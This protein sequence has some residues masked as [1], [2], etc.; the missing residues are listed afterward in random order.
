MLDEAGHFAELGAHHFE[1]L[2]MEELFDLGE[3]FEEDANVRADVRVERERGAFGA[4]HEAHVGGFGGDALRAE[5]VPAAGDVEAAVGASFDEAEVAGDEAH[6]L[7][8]LVREKKR[9]FFYEVRML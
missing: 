6:F 4:A 1:D 8:M 7:S 9:L 3:V 2:P 5:D